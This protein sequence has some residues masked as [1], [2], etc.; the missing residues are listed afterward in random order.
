M[1]MSKAIKSKFQAA[2]EDAKSV[3][4]EAAK[5]AISHYRRAKGVYRT[6]CVAQT[7]E[8]RNAIRESIANK[9][10]LARAIIRN[11]AVKNVT[12]ADLLKKRIVLPAHYKEAGKVGTV[13]QYRAGKDGESDYVYV[14]LDDDAKSIKLPKIDWNYIQ[15][16]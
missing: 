6:I 3:S 15:F 16:V 1:A 2:I 14:K 5:D 4:P 12:Q 9:L 7:V 11:S 10:N 8:H 13:T